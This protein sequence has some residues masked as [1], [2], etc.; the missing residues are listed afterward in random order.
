MPFALSSSRARACTHR[1]TIDR[2]IALRGSGSGLDWRTWG[3]IMCV[4]TAFVRVVAYSPQDPRRLGPARTLDN[5][6]GLRRVRHLLQLN[7][8][9]R[10]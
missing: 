1:V 9:G 7:S 8:R 3:V 10:G 5:A 6:G 4:V 2:L